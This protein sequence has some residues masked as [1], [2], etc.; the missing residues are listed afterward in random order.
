MKCHFYRFFSNDNARYT[1]SNYWNTCQSSHEENCTSLLKSINT[2]K[3]ISYLWWGRFNIQRCQTCLHRVR[4][5]GKIPVLVS[6]ESDKIIL[7][8]IWRSKGPRRANMLLKP[9]PWVI[10]PRSRSEQGVGART[11]RRDLWNGIGNP[12]KG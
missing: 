7:T 12:K 9:T 5:S 1:G 6:V 4:D 10:N 11:G 3:Y 2:L 8:F